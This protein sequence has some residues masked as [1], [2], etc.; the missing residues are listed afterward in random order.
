MECADKMGFVT[1]ADEIIAFLKSKG[2]HV[3]TGRGRHGIKM[4]KGS[5]RIAIPTHSRDIAT[6]TASGILRQA[7]YTINDMMGWRRG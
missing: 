3:E 1:T 7:G 6:G 4:V 5:Q 2:Y